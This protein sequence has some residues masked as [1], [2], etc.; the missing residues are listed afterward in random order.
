ME[1]KTLIVKYVVIFHMQ[2]LIEISGYDKSH[3]T[4]TKNE[5]Q[6]CNAYHNSLG[7]YTP[8]IQNRSPTLTTFAQKTVYSLVYASG[9]W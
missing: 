1:S 9:S 6:R 8:R 4:G 5:M 2:L 3:V 7:K